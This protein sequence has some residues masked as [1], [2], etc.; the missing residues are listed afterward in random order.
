MI[1]II[2]L[3]LLAFWSILFTVTRFFK[4]YRIVRD[5][6]DQATATIVSKRSHVPGSK[7][8]PPGIDVVLQYSINGRDTKSEII[9][10]VDQ[11]EKYEIGNEVEICYY[12]ADNGAIHIASAGDGPRKLMYGYLAA[13]AV[14]IIL[15][16]V[17]WLIAF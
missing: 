2:I 10:P 16:V 5:Y 15:Y 14:E 1:A 3:A 17:I 7:R 11:A 12:V 8:E 13:I 9:V 6:K 4:Y